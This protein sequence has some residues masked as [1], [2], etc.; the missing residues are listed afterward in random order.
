[1]LRYGERGLQGAGDQSRAM[2]CKLIVQQGC[3]PRTAR[4]ANVAK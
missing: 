4:H 1:M 3:G 2:T